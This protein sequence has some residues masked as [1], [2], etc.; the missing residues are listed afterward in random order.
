M[1]SF[2]DYSAH[3]IKERDVQRDKE[4]R[5]SAREYAR[6][7]RARRKKYGRNKE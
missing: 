3:C 7:W 2:P 6:K 1:L 4:H 5:R